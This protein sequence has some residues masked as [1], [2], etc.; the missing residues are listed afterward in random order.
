VT[1]T[2]HAQDFEKKGFKIRQKDRRKVEPSLEE[3]GGTR[4]G[5]HWAEEIA[6]GKSLIISSKEE[7]E[8]LAPIRGKRD[9]T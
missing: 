7:R 8:H 6:E 4:V 9:R 5:S 1:R 3:K 2:E